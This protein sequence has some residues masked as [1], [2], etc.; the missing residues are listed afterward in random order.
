[1]AAP[2]SPLSE[3]ALNTKVPSTPPDAEITWHDPPSSP[4]LD[5]VEQENTVSGLDAMKRDKQFD[6]PSKAKT[7]SK[8]STP[9]EILA[10][11]EEPEPTPRPMSRDFQESPTRSFV[12]ARGSPM[13]QSPTKSVRETNVSEHTLR[14]NEG[15]TITMETVEEV[16]IR[17]DIVPEVEGDYHD[18]TIDDTCFSTF[19]E[20][21]N[22]D[23]TSFAR[24][25]GSP[26]KGTGLD[27]VSD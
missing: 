27:T 6:T 20:I 2:L 12:S 9:F 13:K 24:L 16:H 17:E 18:A 1:M 3:Q 15:L 10:D 4:F 7:P 21:P 14:E 19:S 11:K 25:R 8:T 5:F 22:T 23:M 26:S